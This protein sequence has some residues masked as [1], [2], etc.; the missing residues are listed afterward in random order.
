LLRWLFDRQLIRATFASV[1]E[2][3]AGFD[4]N[5]ETRLLLHY[6]PPNTFQIGDR[7]VSQGFLILKWKKDIKKGEV[8]DLIIKRRIFAT[9]DTTDVTD[10]QGVPVYVVTDHLKGQFFSSS[11]NLHILDMKEKEVAFV[12]EAVRPFLSVFEISIGGKKVGKIQEKFSLFHPRY[13]IDYQG[14]EV[15]GDGVGSYFRISKG[16]VTVG[17]IERPVVSV[18]ENMTLHLG[19]DQ[20]P[21]VVLALAIAIQRAGGNGRV[22]WDLI[23]AP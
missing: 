6:P 5:I 22:G 14:F 21:V 11:T 4:R 1:F 15:T 20:D 18:A 8:M 16:G 7:L 12:H 19:E 13:R 3:E 10:G 23:P 9:T 2:K 17:T